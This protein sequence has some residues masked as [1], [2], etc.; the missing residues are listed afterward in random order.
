MLRL[1]LKFS[2]RAKAALDFDVPL[3]R[4]LTL[5]VK[6]DLERMKNIRS[7]EFAE[8]SS[9]IDTKIDEQFDSV[10][11]EAKGGGLK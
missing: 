5:E 6:E 4:V 10:I 3:V 1:I 2:S 9:A 11:K 8:A 7:K